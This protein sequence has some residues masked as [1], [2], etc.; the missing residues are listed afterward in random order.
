MERNPAP[1]WV[2][3]LAVVAALVVIF[4]P[5]AGRKVEELGSQIFAPFSFHA[6][7]F[8]DSVFEVWRTIESI[9]TLRRTAQQQEEEID[10]LRFEL[11]RMQELELENDDLRRLLDFKRTRPNLR[12]MPVRVIGMDPSGIVKAV[13]IDKGSNDGI[14]E[15]MAVIT[16]R[17]LAGRVIDVKPTSASVLLIADVN[18]SIAARV[19]E[20]DS[21]ASGIVS[22]RKEGGLVM[23]HILQQELVQSGDLVI[24][25]GVGGTLPQGLPIGTVVR[26]QK[27]NV[28]MFQEAILE[29]S[30]DITKLERIHVVLDYPRDE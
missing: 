17:G 28:E 16:W 22:G 8:A 27:R 26:V 6:S 4:Q 10:R 12:L 5:S 9:G 11:V 13:I 24:T 1:W 21:R 15:D 14:Q 18:S 29:P 23:R 19:Q 7:G 25:S 20:L 2:S 3:A 30:A